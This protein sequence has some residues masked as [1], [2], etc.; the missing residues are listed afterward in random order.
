[1]SGALL[2]A[3]SFAATK[4]G[5]TCADKLAAQAP[6]ASKSADVLSKAAD[7]WTAHAQW[8]GTGADAKPE[9]DALT[10]VA[11]DYRDSAA[12][13]RKLSQTVAATK[14]VKGAPHDSSSG[15]AARVGELMKDQAKAQKELA[16]MLQ[17]DA[18]K[19]EKAASQ[20]S[21][22]GMGGSG[23]AGQ[24]EPERKIHSHE[25]DYEESP[26]QN[27]GPDE[28]PMMPPDIE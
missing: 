19:T 12:Q 22:A 9:R 20:M 16:A 14:D 2:A 4:A 17:K 24:V 26:R 15:E 21:Q 25:F 3:P 6:L 28:H 13:L 23:S 5:E 1:M 11:S 7:V 18:E 10:K 8:I 27:T